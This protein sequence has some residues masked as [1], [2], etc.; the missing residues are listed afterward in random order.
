MNLWY[1]DVS[2]FDFTECLES[3]VWEHHR[4]PYTCLF[5]WPGKFWRHL[6]PYSGTNLQ[7]SIFCLG[8]LVTKFWSILI[9]LGK[10]GKLGKQKQP[11]KEKNMPCNH[12]KF[13]SF[14]WLLRSVEALVLIRLRYTVQHCLMKFD[15]HDY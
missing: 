13:Y 5:I 12:G 8:F 2:I 11:S 3:L 7:V 4:L 6:S 10:Q 15:F 9:C 1:K 14:S